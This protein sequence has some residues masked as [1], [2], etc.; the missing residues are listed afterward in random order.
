MT[1]ENNTASAGACKDDPEHHQ[2]GVQ[3]APYAGV[4]LQASVSDVATV[5][6][7]VSEKRQARSCFGRSAKKKYQSETIS[8]PSTC[9]GFGSPLTSGVSTTVV[10][11]SS[12]V[13]TPSGSVIPSSSAAV[14]R[15]VPRPTA[16]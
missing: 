9:T 4:Y 6:I 15:R 3:L 11:T 10:P 7:T 16:F 12:A 13:P 14:N 8:L 1:N 2:Y 5:T